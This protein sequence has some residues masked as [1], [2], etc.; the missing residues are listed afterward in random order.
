MD[1]LAYLMSAYFHQDWDADGGTVDDTVDQ[2]ADEPAHLRSACAGQIGELVRRDL[3][4]G[5]LR[6][7]LV[8]WGC[9]YRAGATDDDFRRWLLGIR[10]QILASLPA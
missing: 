6:E 10:D 2:F 8:A 4:E 7:Q 1:A 5:A 9:D 3:P